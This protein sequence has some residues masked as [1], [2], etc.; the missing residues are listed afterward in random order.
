MGQR[1]SMM[2]SINCKSNG[3]KRFS[4]LQIHASRSSYI[5]QHKIVGVGIHRM[6]AS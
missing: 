1:L 3:G 6:G 5:F 2:L 4:Q